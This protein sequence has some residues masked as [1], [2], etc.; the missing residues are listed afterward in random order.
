MYVYICIYETE[1]DRQTAR[2]RE[3]QR[4]TLSTLTG[5]KWKL[6]YIATSLP[7]FDNLDQKA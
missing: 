6:I 3:T 7:N 5:I 2:E 4:Q 1:G